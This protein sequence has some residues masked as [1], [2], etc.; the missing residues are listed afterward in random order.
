[1]KT[2]QA[3]KYPPWEYEHSLLDLGFVG[4][5]FLP[6]NPREIPV[7][8]SIVGSTG[9]A[10]GTGLRGAGIGNSLRWIS[11][12]GIPGGAVGPE[13]WIYGFVDL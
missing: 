8:F 9:N 11:L 13:Q 6:G 1:M 5:D 2:P 12:V 10:Q 3:C 7:S 4:W